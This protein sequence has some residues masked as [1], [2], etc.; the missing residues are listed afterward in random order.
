MVWFVGIGGFLSLVLVGF[1]VYRAAMK[2]PNDEK[3]MSGNRSPD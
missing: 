3:S 2:E 1:F